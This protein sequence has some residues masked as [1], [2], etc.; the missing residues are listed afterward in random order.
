MILEVFSVKYDGK[1]FFVANYHYICT[2]N[3]R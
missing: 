3:A 1:I 2:I